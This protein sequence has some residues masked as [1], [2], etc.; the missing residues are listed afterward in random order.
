MTS[1]VLIVIGLIAVVIGLAFFAK[2]KRK[3][4][5][6]NAQAPVTNPL[7]PEEIEER[8]RLGETYEQWKRDNNISGP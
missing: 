7:S 8:K 4:D 3:K 6:A 5:E 1:S 2:S